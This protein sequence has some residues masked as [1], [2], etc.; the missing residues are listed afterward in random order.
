V[1]LAIEPEYSPSAQKHFAYVGPNHSRT[2][3]YPASSGDSIYNGRRLSPS[4]ERIGVPGSRSM[5][6]VSSLQGTERNDEISRGILSNYSY[7][8]VSYPDPTLA[9][10]N[11]AQFTDPFTVA[12]ESP[13]EVWTPCARSIL[14]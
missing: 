9:Q 12:S 5:S 8:T 4:N 13:N 6:A 7:L 10:I 11:S 2:W 14:R 3:K 1:E